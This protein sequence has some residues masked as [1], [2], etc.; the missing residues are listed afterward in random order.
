MGLFVPAKDLLGTLT[1]LLYKFLY[2]RTEAFFILYIIYFISYF[3]LYITGISLQMLEQNRQASAKGIP[4]SKI[5]S[6][7]LVN[8]V[9][10]KLE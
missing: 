6:R 4:A 7:P 9:N 3:I 10:V 5:S 2:N 1:I 8:W